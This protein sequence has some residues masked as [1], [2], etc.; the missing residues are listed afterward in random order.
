MSECGWR[1]G[2]VFA[3]VAR[4][5]DPLPDCGSKTTSVRDTR[6]SQVR[7]YHPAQVDRLG[8]GCAAGSGVMNVLSVIGRPTP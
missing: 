3:I 2:G 1:R 6:P 8:I 7:D 5:C 4:G